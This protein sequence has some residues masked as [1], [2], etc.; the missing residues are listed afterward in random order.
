MAASYGLLVGSWCLRLSHQGYLPSNSDR[1]SQVLARKRQEY[2]DYLQQSFGRGE[3]ALD[4]SI[5]HQVF[6]CKE[7]L[8]R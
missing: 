5:W 4:Q 1:R 2:D 7:L 3:A 8:K 6:G